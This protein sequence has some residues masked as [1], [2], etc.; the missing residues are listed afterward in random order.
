MGP[1]A[2]PSP[3]PGKQAAALGKVRQAVQTLQ[4]VVPDLDPTDPIG[5][6]VIKAIGDLAKVAP[7]GDSNPQAAMQQ[8]R[9]MLMQ[10]QQQGP[11]ALLQRAMASQAQPA[12]PTPIAAAP[13]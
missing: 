7:A 8:Q 13:Q 5:K 2:Q 12:G 9:Q 3:N 10:M 11:A 4:E 6:A 1:M